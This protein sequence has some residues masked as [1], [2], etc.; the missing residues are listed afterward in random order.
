MVSRD[1]EQPPLNRDKPQ[2][3]I[4]RQRER[5]SERER[6]KK[7]ARERLVLGDKCVLYFLHE[8]VGAIGGEG[9]MRRY[10]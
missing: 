7:R 3:E 4:E 10:Q 8:D 9:S 2:R 6:E 1:L 5:E